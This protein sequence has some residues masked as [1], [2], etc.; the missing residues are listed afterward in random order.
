MNEGLIHKEQQLKPN[1]MAGVEPS[2][3]T[4]TKYLTMQEIER[5]SPYFPS[6]NINV[7]ERI[8]YS[9]KPPAVTKEVIASCWVRIKRDNVWYKVFLAERMYVM[10]ENEPIEKFTNSLLQMV[11]IQSYKIQFLYQLMNPRWN[12]IDDL[13]IEETER[14]MNLIKDRQY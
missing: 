10:G 5:Y 7:W 13:Q 11:M 1:G 12:P 9:I 2:P 3:E 6:V 14:L 4:F 8:D